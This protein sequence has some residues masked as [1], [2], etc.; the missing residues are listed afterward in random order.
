VKIGSTEF[1]NAKSDLAR[2]EFKK[3]VRA[4]NKA[5]YHAVPYG[6]V[7]QTDKLSLPFASIGDLRRTP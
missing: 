4:S 3:A 2:N 7:P 6:T 1:D 5:A